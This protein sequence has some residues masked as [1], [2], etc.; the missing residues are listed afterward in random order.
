MK[1][2]VKLQPILIDTGVVWGETRP[3]YYRGERNITRR[4]GREGYFLAA[5][6]YDFSTY[7]NNC[8]IAKWQH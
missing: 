4:P 1:E 7:F 2:T 3:M 5:G 6:V 8:S